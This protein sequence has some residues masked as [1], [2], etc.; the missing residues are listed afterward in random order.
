MKL[1]VKFSKEG[2]VKFISHLDSLRLFHRAVQRAGIPIL[3]SEG[4]N[5]H[6]K[7]S[8]TQP[9][10]V[11]MESE[12]EWMEMEVE[13]GT[14]IS[15]IAAELNS[16][17][18][19]GIRILSVEEKVGKES[20]FGAIKTTEYRFLFP[21]SLYPNAEALK[22]SIE[23]AEAADEIMVPRKKKQGRKKIWV[24]ED[25]RPLIH[26][27]EL[28]EGEDFILRALLGAGNEGNL[29]PDRFLQGV[30][31]QEDVDGVQIRRV[32]SLDENEKQIS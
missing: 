29:R 28:E 27:L 4:F 7:L 10:S 12:G 23:R 6:M 14:D 3:W 30:F 18:P 24:D 1:K 19:P 11:G 22:A 16:A 21:R 32:R 25:I 2:M 9:L 26:K 17:L 31:P 5:P 20:L 15:T 13:D 8:I